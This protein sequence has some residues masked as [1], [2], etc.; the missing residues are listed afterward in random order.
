[1]NGMRC[2]ISVEALENGFEVEVPDMEAM[3]KNM[4]EKRK[5]KGYESYT[6]Y[7]GDFTK[8][9]AAKN[10]KEV[11]KLVNGALSG[12]PEMDFDTAFK[13]ASKAVA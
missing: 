10:V 1:M 2:R 7:A 8:K 13:E 9:Y 5:Q 12:L 11:I 3:K 4:A 6:P